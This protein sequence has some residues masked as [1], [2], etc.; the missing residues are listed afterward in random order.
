MLEDLALHAQR[1]GRRVL[2]TL[3]PMPGRR[4]MLD[5]A[6][7]ARPD[8]AVELLPNLRERRL[9]HAPVKRRGQDRP[10]T[11]NRRA[12]EEMVAGISDGRLRYLLRR[13]LSLLS[14]LL[15]LAHDTVGL[16][17]VL[18]RELAMLAQYLCSR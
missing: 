13:L 4:P 16:V 17:A 8:S 5:R 2:R 3:V 15:R 11:L 12:L 6:E 1:L 14:M 18:R 10:F 7:L 9:A